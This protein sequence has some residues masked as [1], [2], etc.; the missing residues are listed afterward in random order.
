MFLTLCFCLQGAPGNDG[1][2]GAKGNPVSIFLVLTSIYLAHVEV[3]LYFGLRSTTL[4]RLLSLSCHSCTKLTVLLH[5][6]AATCRVLLE[7][8]V[9]LDSLDPVDP[10]DLRVLLVPPD[11]RETL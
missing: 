10:Q 8:L 1:A 2:A 6:F 3:L 7:L 11:L 4:V 9:L 5:L